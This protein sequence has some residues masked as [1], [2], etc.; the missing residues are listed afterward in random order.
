[1]LTETKKFIAQSAKAQN[2]TPEMTA[3]LMQNKI[4]ISIANIKKTKKGISFTEIRNFHECKEIE[5]T[6]AQLPCYDLFNDFDGKTKNAINTILNAIEEDRDLNHTDIKNQGAI[7]AKGYEALKKIKYYNDFYEALTPEQ[8]KTFE[9]IAQNYLNFFHNGLSTFDFFAIQGENNQLETGDYATGYDTMT[10]N[11]FFTRILQATPGGYITGVDNGGYFS[12]STFSKPEKIA[13]EAIPEDILQE[14]DETYEKFDSDVEIHKNDIIAK[15]IKKAA[16]L[17]AEADKEAARLEKL[18]KEAKAQA[19]KA[20]KAKPIFNK[21]NKMK[22]DSKE[23]ITKIVKEI[24]ESDLAKDQISTL[25]E[26]IALAKTALGIEP[27]KAPGADKKEAPKAEIQ[28]NKK[29]SKAF[30]MEPEELEQAQAE[31]AEN[32]PAKKAATPKKTA[33]KKTATPKAEGTPEPEEKPKRQAPKKKEAA[34]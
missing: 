11:R 10:S 18:E 24:N 6:K 16:R 3:F 17:Q 7:T 12:L 30:E 29:P 14:I 26:K 23:A 34:K 2:L 27:R 33:A 5:L 22:L 1:M 9:R 8:Q 28:A 13:K 20:E 21:L 32:K 25:K 4:I 31:I 15:E 19:A